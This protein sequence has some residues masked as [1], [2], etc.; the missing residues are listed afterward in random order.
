MPF[1]Q[2]VSD[3]SPPPKEPKKAA[4]EEALK[5]NEEGKTAIMGGQKQAATI[6]ENDAVM[7]DAQ[8]EAVKYVLPP[9]PKLGCPKH[10][11]DWIHILS[12]LLQ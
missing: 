5:E 6:A 3:K 9:L 10:I 4:K 11:A 12:C 8:Q 1:T 7:P 2:V